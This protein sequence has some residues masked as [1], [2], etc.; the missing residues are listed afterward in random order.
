MSTDLKDAVIVH[1]FFKSDF[2]G[3]FKNCGSVIVLEGR[4]SL[5]SGR[6]AVENLQKHGILPTVIADNMAGYLFSKGAVKEVWLSAQASDKTGAMCEIGSLILAVLAKKHSV[7]VYISAASRKS[8]AFGKA[9]DLQKFNG[10]GVVGG[11]V[12]AFVPLIE[13]VP[14]KYI[15]KYHE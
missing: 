9:G 6:E 8:K 2:F 1:G 14:K 7:P 15:G 13:W 10:Q 3:S 5:E 12:K 11:K 4:P